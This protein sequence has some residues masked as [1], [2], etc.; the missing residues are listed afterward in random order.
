MN[1]CSRMLFLH[2]QQLVSSFKKVHQEDILSISRVDFRSE[3]AP[4]CPGGGWWRR[5]SAQE[6]QPV[7]PRSRACLGSHWGAQSLIL[8]K[9]TLWIHRMGP[10]FF[11]WNW[12]LI[13]QRIRVL[14]EVCL[15][16][17]ALW[18]VSEQIMRKISTKLAGLSDAKVNLKD[19]I[20]RL[21]SWGFLLGAGWGIEMFLFYE[22]ASIDRLLCG[23]M[24]SRPYIA[25]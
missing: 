25:K 12:P 23:G 15:G 3:Q 13:S 11:M 8:T 22:K 19:F 21:S 17:L 6:W 2:C 20:L 10:M 1:A 4:A 7:W 5:V 24:C 9:D 14:H 18:I 16:H